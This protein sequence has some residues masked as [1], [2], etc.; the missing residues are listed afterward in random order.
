MIIVSVL[1]PAYNE[2]A[3]ILEILR[4]VKAVTYTGVKFEILVIDDGSNDRTIEL[5]EANL[6]LFSQLIK[7]PQNGGKGAAVKAGLAA[8]TGDYILFQDAD[9]EYDPADFAKMLYPVVEHQADVVMGSRFIAPQNMRVSY[10]WHKVGNYLITFI[11]NILNNTTFT[12]VYSCYLMFRRDLIYAENLRTYGWEQHAEILSIA[13]QRG[14][15]FYEVPISYHG[16]TYE[17]GKKIRAHHTIAVIWTMI[18][19]RLFG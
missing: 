10:F 13:T 14:K 6:D 18:R 19:M 7:M 15:V 16:R 3:T 2:D 11:F 17:D 12:D 1:I 9:L 5:L 4:K 8:A